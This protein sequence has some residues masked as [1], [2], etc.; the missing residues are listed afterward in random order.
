MKLDRLLL[1]GRVSQ[2]GWVSCVVI[3]YVG[4]AAIADAVSILVEDLMSTVAL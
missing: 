3:R 2:S 4:I 1:L